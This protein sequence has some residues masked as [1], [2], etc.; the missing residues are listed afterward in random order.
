MS[1]LPAL[2]LRL[3][4]RLSP[5]G[6]AEAQREVTHLPFSIGRAPDNDWALPDPG[7]VLSKHH[8]RITANGETW[9]IT[10]TSSN[11]TFVNGAGLDPDLPQALRNGDR[12]VFGAYEIEA[13]LGDDTPQAAGDAGFGATANARSKAGARQSNQPDDESFTGDRLTGDP[14]PS[15][16]DDMLEA[17]RPSVGLPPD[18]DPLT[19]AEELSE[20]PYAAPDHVPE[21]ETH[22]R[23]PRPGFE[24][25]PDDWDQDPEPRPTPRASP[26]VQGGDSDRDRGDGREREAT[27]PSPAPQLGVVPPHA[28]LVRE[29]DEAGGSHG[30]REG[31]PHR[32]QDKRDATNE[33]PPPLEGGG[34]GEGS[35]AANLRSTPSP[36]PLPRGEGERPLAPAA[37]A[38]ES[39]AACI[40]EARAFAAFAAGA[41]MAGASVAQ[42]GK[43]LAALGAVFRTV[44]TGLRRMMI[45]RAAV[46]GEFRIDQTIIRAAGNNPLKFSADDDDALTAL[47]GIGR[48]GGMPPAQAIGEALRDI[49]RHELAVAAA[50][51]Q[52]V[53]EVLE[54]FDPEQM[55]RDASPGRLDRLTGA[56]ERRA[57]RRYAAQHADVMRMLS[58]D[59]DS[60][61]GRSFGRAYEAALADIA[62]EDTE[63]DP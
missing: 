33:T 1:A 49:R 46:K 28:V 52:A 45:A 59:F 56:N 57:W 42:P 63:S 27:G 51:Q 38:P 10:D 17:A 2:R 62:A 24:M 20:S 43:T 23:P 30:E 18:F 6:V 37:A 39:P 5:G 55:M 36:N 58:D 47:L 25:L 12:L 60:V 16:D 53:R 40:G 41:G 61:F 50:M 32:R 26:P 31:P 4:T 35:I 8:C 29:E 13:L 11:G 54:Q 48:H 19:P 22:F 34:W 15:L 7:R 3:A 9:Q 21:L 14:F 44:V